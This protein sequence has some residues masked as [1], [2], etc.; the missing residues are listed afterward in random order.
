MSVTDGD[1]VRGVLHM[2]MVNGDDAVNIFTWLIDKVSLG[3]WTDSEIGTFVTDAIELAFSVIV[4][5]LKVATTYDTVDIYK[6]L[7]GTWDYLTTKVPDIDGEDSAQVVSP[8]VCLLAT[9]YT[10]KNRTFGRKFL[11]GITEAHVTEGALSVE[12]L[13]DLADFAEEYITAYSG[14]TMGVLDFLLPGVWDEAHSLFN[15]FNGIAVVKN[16]LSYQRRRKTNVG[17]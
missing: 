15:L 5:D 2:T 12:S 4:A 7:A 16:T 13:A 11:Y 17:V 8:G 1:V 3:D 10:D 14:G 6:Q 9:A